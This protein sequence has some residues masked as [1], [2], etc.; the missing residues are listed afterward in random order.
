[1]VKIMV[2]LSFLYAECFYC[3]YSKITDTWTIVA[4]VVPV[5]VHRIH[6]RTGR[7][8]HR[9]SKKAAAAA[10][11]PAMVNSSSKTTTAFH[12]RNNSKA[13]GAHQIHHHEMM[14]IHKGVASIVTTIVGLVAVAASEA[15]VVAVTIATIANVSA[16]FASLICKRLDINCI[17]ILCSITKQ[18]TTTT[19]TVKTILGRQCIIYL[20]SIHLPMKKPIHTILKRNNSGN[21]STIY[22][23]NTIHKSIRVFQRK[24]IKTNERNEDCE[25][26]T[27]L[28]QYCIF[29]SE[30]W[31]KGLNF[32]SKV[33][34]LSKM[35]KRYFISEVIF[36]HKFRTK[37]QSS[38]KPNINK[39]NIANQI[40]YL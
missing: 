1:M 20:I 9:T 15:V 28:S 10:V 25:M 33:F 27:K 5:V 13:T 18:A 17:L 26:Q 36:S 23:E 3:C 30:A 24:K 12:H 34:L 6:H 14:E 38:N 29:E 31:T 11:L 37:K 2:N 4:V 40:I 32:N 19:A 35:K 21:E 7:F 39:T 8:H 22:N 16:S